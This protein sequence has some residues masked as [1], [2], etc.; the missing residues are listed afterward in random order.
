MEVIFMTEESVRKKAPKKTVRKAV[1][2]TASVTRAPR[3]R[4]AAA[5]AE[6]LETVPAHRP[7]RKAPTPVATERAT[8]AQSQKFIYIGIGV[9]VAL[10]ITS[11]IIGFTDKG[12]INV[13]SIIDMRVSNA[14]PE[15][16][17]RF[18][19]AQKASQGVPVIDGGLTPT[20][21]PP[22]TPPP[23]PVATTT[24]QTASSTDATD[25]EAQPAEAG[26]TV[27]DDASTEFDTEPSD[28]A[29]EIPAG[30]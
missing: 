6:E 22:R 21:L 2:R 12:S 23:E 17:I 25:T 28:T 15:D 30:T 24:D 1:A 16:K 10:F 18:E 26:E 19:Q 8:A 11:A 9:F 29:D 3:T 20:D 13:R 4:K 7:R 5:V 27:T 14:S